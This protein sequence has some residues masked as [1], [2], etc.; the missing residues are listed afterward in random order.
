MVHD[1]QNEAKID[2]NAVFLYKKPIIIAGPFPLYGL[3]SISKHV[4]KSKGQ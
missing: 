1:P 4:T 3:I 2:Q